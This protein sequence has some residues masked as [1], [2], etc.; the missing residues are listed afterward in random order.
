MSIYIERSH[1]F[2]LETDILSRETE[3]LPIASADCVVRVRRA[4]EYVIRRAH[5]YTEKHTN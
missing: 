5:F 1:K 2:V 3:L 4:Q